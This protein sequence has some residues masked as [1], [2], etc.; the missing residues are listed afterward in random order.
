[1]DKFFLIVLMI[2]LSPL[3][4]FA[5]LSS[6]PA[7]ISVN[8]SKSANFIIRGGKPPY[9][10]LSGTS[11][12]G[13]VL[14]YTD[15]F[16]YK[17]PSHA[18]TAT[19]VV[20]DVYGSTVRIPV[21][22]NALSAVPPLTIFS[23][24]SV[25]A[26]SSKTPVAV[27]GGKPPYSFIASS[28]EVITENGAPVYVAPSSEASAVTITVQDSSGS[29][30]T[31]N[32]SVAPKMTLSFSSANVPYNWAQ[33]IPVN[34]GKSPYS[35]SLIS[36]PG[37]LRNDIY[38]A[39]GSGAG[40]A[41]IRVTDS[42]GQ[43]LFFTVTVVSGTTPVE[44]TGMILKGDYIREAYAPG[45]VPITPDDFM[46]SRNN[47][48]QR[49]VEPRNCALVNLA[50]PVFSWVY[51]VDVNASVPMTFY[52]KRPDGSII[53]HKTSVPRLI[54]PQSLQSGSYEWS[55]E[56][57]SS[58]GGVVRSATRRFVIPANNLFQIPSGTTMAQIVQ[59]KIRP[60][61][62]PT[63]HS[64]T[65][66]ASKL[67]SGDLKASYE[68]FLSEA[69]RLSTLPAAQAPQNLTRANFSSDAEFNTWQL[70]LRNLT[71]DEAYAIEV[72][73]FASYFTN[74]S[75][76]ATAAMNRVVALAD[77]DPQGPTSEAR[78]DQAN[79]EIFLSLALGLDLFQTKLTQNQRAKI[80]V[81]LQNRL[82]QVMSKFSGLN[83]YPYD[84]HLLTATHYV[85]EALMYAVG[86]PEFTNASTLLGS[87]WETLITTAGSWGGHDGGFGNGTSYGW[88]A[89]TTT[90]R[91]LAGIKLISDINLS[92][93]PPF[94]NLGNTQI[95]FTPP[96]T[97]LRGQFGDEVEETGHYFNYT[98]EGFRLYASLTGK[99]EHHWYWKAYPQNITYA[100]AMQPFV[101]LI[102]GSEFIP[103]TTSI[104][105]LPTSY[106]FEDAGVVAMHSKTTDTNRTSVFFRSSKFGSFNHSHA[107][108]NAFTFV[109]KGK[110]LLISGGYYPYYNSPHHA[111]VGRATR[112]K[113][114]LTFDGGIGQSEPVFSPSAP[115]APTWLMDT[116]GKL[117]N[118]VDDGTWAITTGDATKAY[119]GRNSS[120]GD[121]NPMLSNA[122]RTVAYN[123]AE[124]V[125]VVYDW[126]TSSI[127]RKWELNFQTLQRPTINN[128]RSIV[129]R[130][131]PASA[132]IDIY[133][134]E[135]SF[136]TQ[137]GFPIEPEA[138]RPPQYQ[139]RFSVRNTSSEFVSVTVI[140]EDC[141]TVPVSIN[142][143]SGTSEASFS[144][145]GKTLILTGR[146]V[147]LR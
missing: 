45:C 126:A 92:Q 114:A 42:L 143:R 122:V 116:F 108:N 10:V 9:R 138:S 140:R 145:N 83:R 132:C 51:P 21:I 88:Y 11:K 52:L 64:F 14:K 24:I 82:S 8:A 99:A 12:F 23:S 97:R 49:R 111:L 141:R 40:V 98:R 89:L 56:Y 57:T 94:G 39:P 22:V 147:E 4:S 17:A 53:T 137:S 71:R 34:G 47:I 142:F 133:G 107:D 3:K 104:P 101:Y 131:D 103:N 73:G 121:L 77:W 79:R 136:T 85:N 41:Q 124:G 1:M 135:G 74:N 93:F 55:V 26:P 100:G 38:T 6:V 44:K 125:V 102:A 144:I 70:S 67:M 19:I 86:T 120:T 69:K 123:R 117:V 5:Q 25:V 129:V 139:S 84:S 75:S 46:E 13:L 127:A 18:T 96:A 32:L 118:F 35:F 2:I 115:G 95:A 80:V 20:K 76:Y 105:L 106:L 28:G 72:L 60:R 66:I 15:Y 61:V 33:R 113:N 54:L 58:R 128:N 37:T 7:S 48:N 30:K 146:S 134:P 90:A 62:L 119:Q 50:T 91:T 16:T 110:E 43:S 109:S 87:A 31:L 63:G 27:S 29:S 112:F 65:S 68:K 130:N 81:S 36:G 59:S 78:Q